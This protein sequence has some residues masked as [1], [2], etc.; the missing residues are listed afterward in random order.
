MFEIIPI[1][2]ILIKVPKY[3]FIQENSSKLRSNS[4]LTTTKQNQVN[5]NNTVLILVGS[6][7]SP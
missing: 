5:K 1:E 6:C 3:Y 4:N 7:F 2:K